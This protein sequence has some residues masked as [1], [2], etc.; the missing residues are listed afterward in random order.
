MAL[1]ASPLPQAFAPGP[2]PFRSEQIQPAA[3]RDCFVM[4]WNSPH[5][6]GAYCV[7]NLSDV[8]SIPNSI[9]RL[10]GIFAAIALAR[11]RPFSYRPGTSYTT[12]ENGCVESRIC[13]AAES[14]FVGHWNEPASTTS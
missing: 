13:V 6:Y 12:A 4:L 2:V 5:T 3:K 14:C 7:R 11:P 8:S 1:T 9:G 10:L